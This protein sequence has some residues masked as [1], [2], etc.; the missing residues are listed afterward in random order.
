MSGKWSSS[1]RRNELPADWSRIRAAVARRAHGQCEWVGEPFADDQ[2]SANHPE[3]PPNHRCTNAGTDC[4]HRDNRND[5]NINAL[6]W[7]CHEHHAHKTQAEA[8]AAANEQRER[9]THP[10]TRAKHPGLI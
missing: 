7:L 2:P 10:T 3:P 1:N 4:D 5:H 8:Q 6:Q 9:L